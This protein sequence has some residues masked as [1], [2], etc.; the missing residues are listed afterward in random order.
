MLMT[1][2]SL[3][4]EEELNGL[5]V[6]ERQAVFDILNE[7]GNNGNSQLL[8]QLKYAD[9][10]EM[11]VDIETF[12]SND[13]YLG[14]AWKDSSGNLKIY[15]YWLDRLKELFP[16]N[17]TTSKNTFI[18]SGARGL[19]KS[20]IS[21][22]IIIPYLI[23]RIMC[24]KNPLEFYSL[25]P[26]EKI[27]FAF[28][29]I[30]L[31]LAEEIAIDKF[32]KTIQ[33]SPWF[34][35]KGTMTRR[36]NKN[37]WLPPEPI[38]VII[39]SDSSSVI[40]QPIYACFI[41]EISFIKNMDIE[42]QKEKALDMVDT[43][44]GGM[45]TRFIHRGK[46]PTLLLLA[47]SKR[48]EKSFMETHIKQK[49]ASEPENVLIVDEAVWVVK[50]KGT[51]SD[52]TFK[53]AVGN[54]FLD[55]LV[56]KDDKE[57]PALLQRGYKII[58]VPIDF[59]PNFIDDIDRALRDYAGISSSELSKYINGVSVQ[60][61]ITKNR[62]NP[63]VKD[64][65]EIGN[66]PDDR[67]QYY[68]FFDISKI[69]EN[70]R[71]KPLYIHLDMS[72]TGDK[73]GIAG[74]FI[75]GKKVS[76]DGQQE[77]DLYYSLG[78]SVAIKAPKGRQVSF[79]KNRNF[80]RWLRNNGFNVKRI[81]AD[82]FQSADL[83]QALQSEGFNC[84]ILSVDRVNTDHICLPYQSFRSAIYENRIELYDSKLLINEI[85]DLERNINTGK[86]DHPPN[87][88]KDTS[89]AICGAMFTASKDAEQ[90]A[91]DYGESLTVTTE[92]N[93]NNSRNEVDKYINDFSDSIL[94]N[95]VHN[96]VNNMIYQNN[97]QEIPATTFSDYSGGILVW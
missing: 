97:N 24:M 16:D 78:F 79:E 2:I 82:T 90:Y 54:K 69:P 70:I 44:I 18:A 94:R 32:Q 59:K 81:T 77:K 39:G 22:G 41:D 56:V 19:G 68:N 3:I 23:H 40:G 37:Y 50:P 88:S 28:M 55:S 11:P 51:Y 36:N 52:E 65:L 73:T 30:K 85:T 43:A 46:N 10:K 57:V 15:P 58:D 13:L 21:A 7:L 47:S 76:T 66:A 63:F 35:S 45:K 5:S 31:E 96:T 89:D 49:M 4:S 64:I 1:N 61:C 53:V 92:F 72:L 84:E 93:M 48:S 71:Y 14:Q 80:I 17:I 9:Y 67:L 86:I 12:I 29:N 26:T 38:N 34:M 27:T 33:L 20:E 8:D 74:V 6:Q 83:I 91:F 42:K 25:K 95:S 87:G 75:K 60:S 62:I